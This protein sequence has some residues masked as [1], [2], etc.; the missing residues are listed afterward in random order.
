MQFISI[1]GSF[2]QAKADLLEA[3][4]KKIGVEF[5]LDLFDS[6]SFV[7]ELRSLALVPVIFT[8]KR[9]KEGGHFRGEDQKW[10]TLLFNLLSSI[11]DYLDLDYQTAPS[12]IDKIHSHFPTI[13]LICSFH[14][15]KKTP[16]DL[17][18]I[19]QVM[20]QLD[21]SFYKMATFAHS[22][23][24][25]LQMLNFIQKER[26]KGTPI[27]GMCMGKKGEI[28]RILAPIVDSLLNYTVIS[29]KRVTA[30]GQLS[31][32]ILEN[33]YRYATLSETTTLYG[34][35][36]DP[37]D[38][39]IGHLFHNRAFEKLEIHAIYIKMGVTKEE[40]PRFF[41]LIRSLPFQGLSVT[42]PL[43]EAVM[44]YLNTKDEE[45]EMIG[46]TNTLAL[47][48]T[49]W[50]GYNTD[51]KGALDAIERQA[52]VFNQ[53]ILIYGAGGAARALAFE[54]IKR[55]GN[56]L[57]LSRNKEQGEKVAKN[58]GGQSVSLETL[59]FCSFDIFMNTTPTD[60]SQ[61]L[62]EEILKN[63]P[64]IFDVIFHQKR[65]SLRQ[66][67]ETLGVPFVSGHQMFINQAIGQLEIWRNLSLS[68]Y[69]FN[70]PF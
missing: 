17:D 32:D 39:S 7:S 9:E 25:S 43:K 49:G 28:T 63:R 65:S 52:K 6:L 14:C 13:S 36:G 27:G 19:L 47:E 70:S 61:P 59:S 31:L 38:H 21:A 58:L 34:L 50:K 48:K 55:G 29:E 56:V 60:P 40:L 18:Q 64:L 3:N 66:V 20:Q 46:A 35:I 23:L 15:F 1:G 68:D 2:L 57:I 62:I 54:T 37:I 12:F 4:Q 30:P 53:N 22:T 45:V 11:P 41:K 5:R 44:D 26:K 10:E 67:A 16:H 69:S 8:L 24:D 42:M 33:R 51:G